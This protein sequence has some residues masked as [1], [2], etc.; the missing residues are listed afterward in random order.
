MIAATIR[1]LSR[2]KASPVSYQR[3]RTDD[4]GQQQH[5]GR[6]DPSTVLAATFGVMQDLPALGNFDFSLGA[7]V[8]LH[9]TPEQL[10]GI[11]GSRPASFKVFLRLRLPVPAMGRMRDATMMQPRGRM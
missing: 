6:L 1:K 10:I 8:T 11:Y 2:P 3:Q 9:R 4:R 5:G 7:D